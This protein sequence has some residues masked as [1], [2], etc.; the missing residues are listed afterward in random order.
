M[1]HLFDCIDSFLHL[2][3]LILHITFIRLLK[4]LKTNTDQSGYG[5]WKIKFL[6]S[7]KSTLP[8]PWW[9]IFCNN[10]PVNLSYTGIYN[11]INIFCNSSNPKKLFLFTSNSLN[12][13]FKI[14][15][16]CVPSVL[17]INLNLIIFIALFTSSGFT[18][19]N[20]T[21]ATPHC[22][23]MNLTK[24]SSSGMFKLKSL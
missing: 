15:S 18:F 1:V 24:V 7:S 19:F 12:N 4:T 17:W 14:N 22:E 2:F 6:N 20:C 11:F 13:C 9:S 8:I 10:S 5:S 16:S 21:Y 3:Y 23:F